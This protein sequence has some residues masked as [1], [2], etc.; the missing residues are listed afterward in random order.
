[1][2]AESAYPIF[3]KNRA[4]PAWKLLA[5]DK[6][7]VI[8]AVLGD[9]FGEGAESI[10]ATEFFERVDACLAALRNGDA[11]FRMSAR[12][13]AAEWLREKWLERRLPDGADEDV[14]SLTVHSAQALRWVSELESPRSKVTE[15][16]LAIVIEAAIRFGEETDP[17]IESR[18]ERLYR[19]REEITA[20]IAD[21]EHG[22]RIEAVDE[23]TYFERVD[24]LTGQ[25]EELLGDFYRLRSAI[26]GINETLRR[27]ALS[28]D[29]P[30]GTVLAGT[31]NALAAMRAT[32][33]YKTFHAFWTMLNNPSESAKYDAAVDLILK[34]PHA[35]GLPAE[36]R[37]GLRFLFRNL[38]SRAS[39]VHHTT[40]KLA[41]GLRRVVEGTGL[42]EENAF[43]RRL[44]EMLDRLIDSAKNAGLL[45]RTGAQ[46]GRATVRPVSPE[47]LLVRDERKHTPPRRPVGRKTPNEE[48]WAAARTLL[49]APEADPA[50]LLESV[51]RLVRERG[52]CTIGDVIAAFPPLEGLA[53]V[54]ALMKLAAEHGVRGSGTERIGW[55]GLD[56]VRREG[57][58]DEWFFTKEVLK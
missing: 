43:N 48:S 36:T 34:S 13:A 51:R 39:A 47:A 1:M 44:A 6:A 20:Q 38:L 32:P 58:V 29:A 55:R 35:A 4:E 5:A 50:E 15:S 41:Q 33:E 28:A 9:V 54:T 10:P 2:K 14:Y 37:R 53:T 21:I 8:L 27:Q 56:E 30:K 52:Q 19:R 57:D 3:I 23:R 17:S 46:A 25:S 22:G 24:E 40:T 26:E 18:L 11:D 42:R 31:F 12:D 16:R 7:G 45:E 49:G